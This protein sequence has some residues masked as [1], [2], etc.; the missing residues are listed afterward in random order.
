MGEFTSESAIS[1]LKEHWDVVASHI[2]YSGIGKL[3]DF[4]DGILSRKQI[5]NELSKFEKCHNFNA[6]ARRISNRF[7]LCFRIN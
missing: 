6:P 2:A 1:H 3:V 4:Y 7:F 5:K